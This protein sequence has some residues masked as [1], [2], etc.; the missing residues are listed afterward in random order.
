MS[1]LE[2]DDNIFFYMKLIYNN[3]IPF[4]GFSAMNV[5]GIWLFVRRVM[6]DG[7]RVNPLLSE[8]TLNHEEIHSAQYKE[9]GY[10]GFLVWYLIEWVVRLVCEFALWAVRAKGCVKFKEMAHAAY[11][12]I[13]LEQEAYDFEMWRDY[14]KSG[15][16]D[17]YQWWYCLFVRGYKG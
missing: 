13:S 14:L 4:K 6:R 16:R 5:L 7:Q 12:N 10:I 8:R 2:Q 11:R 3:Y 1:Y 17:H 15:V 9:M